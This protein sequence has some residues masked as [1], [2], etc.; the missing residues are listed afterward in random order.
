MLFCFLLFLTL[1]FLD[2]DPSATSTGN[3]NVAR[4]ASS[5]DSLFQD[6]LPVTTGAFSSLELS[7]NISLSWRFTLGR[8]TGEPI[9]RDFNELYNPSIYRFQ[10]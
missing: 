1:L 9:Q 8:F 7:V 2:D 6:T 3:N 5:S 10:W 4:R